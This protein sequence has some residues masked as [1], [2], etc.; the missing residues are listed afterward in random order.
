MA[1]EAMV[2]VLK[3]SD[4]DELI[5]QG[6]SNTAMVLLQPN[7]LSIVTSDGPTIVEDKEE[8]PI[9]LSNTPTENGSGIERQPRWCSLLKTIPPSAGKEKLLFIEP[10]FKD[11]ILQVEE[12]ILNLGSKE[13]EDRVVGFFLDKKLPFSIVKDAVHKK[14]KLLGQ[15]DIAL[16]DD[17]Y[18]FKFHNQQDREMVLEEGT[19]H[20]AEAELP[21]TITVNTLSEHPAVIELE[22]QWKPL[23]CTTCKAFGHSTIKCGKNQS[24]KEVSNQAHRKTNQNKETWQTVK[25][26]SKWVNRGIYREKIADSNTQ[27]GNGGKS[28]N[29][30]KQLNLEKGKN[31]E[32]EHEANNDNNQVTKGR[33][34]NL[35]PTCRDKINSKNNNQAS[36]SKSAG[37]SAQKG[38][39]QLANMFATLAEEDTTTVETMEEGEISKDDTFKTPMQGPRIGEQI[40]QSLRRLTELSDGD[41]SSDE[42]PE[43]EDGIAYDIQKLKEKYT[44]PVMSSP[45]ASKTRNAKSRKEKEKSQESMITQAPSEHERAKNSKTRN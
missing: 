20:I 29:N 13:W 45:I 37:N 35:S 16:D 14:W 27:D 19:I 8:D 3:S 40:P 9:I 17:T 12:E 6:K 11:G 21:N 26:K 2:S 15:V 7:A 30:N 24:E 34:Q 36:S 18:Y 42:E 5:D 23:I 32:V 33:A 39:T 10:I 31:D 4:S 43:L 25:P 44:Q 41:E 1:G 22:Y 28:Q 38:T